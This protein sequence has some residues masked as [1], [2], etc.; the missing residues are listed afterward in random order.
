MLRAH[1]GPEQMP[2]VTALNIDHLNNFNHSFGRR[3]GDQLLQQVAERL[4]AHVGNDE[5]V[6]DL[7]GGTFVLVEPAFVA[8]DQGF[9]SLLF[10]AVFAQSFLLEGPQ[11]TRLVP[12]GPGSL[13]DRRRRRQHP[14]AKG[15]SGAEAC[16]GDRRAVL[17]LQ[18]RN[19]P[20]NGRTAGP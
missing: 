3:F 13:S 12:L 1:P 16:E 2:T 9:A 11:R 20:R 4:R 6:A 5:R 10:K 14:G 17:A 18:T 15:R 19:A 8:A 7:G